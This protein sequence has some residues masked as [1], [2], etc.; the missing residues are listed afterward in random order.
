MEFL[1]YFWTNDFSRAVIAFVFIL[2]VIVFVHE[3]GHYVIARWNG[4]RV[5]V[6]SIGFGRE[7]IGWND[8]FGTRW[9]ISILPFGGYVKMFGDADA[10]STPSGELRS[11]TPEE[12]LVSFHHK[13]LGQRTAIVFGGPIANFVLAVVILAVLFATVGQRITPPEIDTVVAGGAAEAAGMRPGDVV[14]RIDGAEIERFE[15]LQQVVRANA[16]VELRVVVLRDDAEVAFA[17]TPRLVEIRDRFGG[18]HRIGQ[19][20]VGRSGV[21][22]VRHGPT[23]AVWAAMKETARL[24]VV[25]LQAVGQ[26]IVGTRGTDELGGPIFIAQVAGDM[27]E[28]GIVAVFLFMA[29]LSV[30]LGLINLFPIPMLDGGHLLFYAFEAIRGK[31]LGERAQTYGFRIV[32][33]AWASNAARISRARNRNMPEFQ[34]YRPVASI[35]AACSRPGF[36][37]KRRNGSALSPARSPRGSGSS[38]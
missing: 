26:I 28:N 36:S 33:G 23:P 37:T 3:M 14:L 13:R 18:M 24:T 4:V 6:F 34:R 10:A 22:F 2:S 9:K 19:I 31:P 27:A 7:L 35:S 25:T 17:V 20:G 16:G 8:R 5:E 38:R 1:T 30:N 12:K 21:T 29:L 11:M 15:T 32:S